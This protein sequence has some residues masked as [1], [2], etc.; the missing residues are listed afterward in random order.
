MEQFTYDSLLEQYKL[1]QEQLQYYKEYDSLTGLYNKSTFYEK[2]TLLLEKTPMPSFYIICIDIER[3]KFINELYGTE[4]GNALLQYLSKQLR[5][6]VFTDTH[7]FG[8]LSA[9]I[10]ATCTPANRSIESIETAILQAFESAPLDIHVIPA[11]GIYPTE[12]HLMDVKKMCDRAIFSLNSIKGNYSKHCAVYDDT[13]WH[14]LLQE[15]EMVSR[16]DAA[17]QNDEFVVYMQ[18]KCNMHTGRI[19]GAEALVRW[20]HPK[21]GLIAPNVFIPV[22]EHNGFI[23]KLDVY[24]WES[25]AKW[26]HERKTANLP[27]VPVSVNVSRID[28]I[29]MDLFETLESIIKRYDIPANMLELEITESAYTSGLEDIAITVEKLMH[30]GYTVLM[31]DFG[32][33]YSSLNM[34]KDINI[35]ILKLDMRF[36]DNTNQKSRDILESIVRMAKWLNLH[37]IAEGVE[38]KNQEDFLLN[39][40]CNYA[41]GYYYYR[42]MPLDEFSCLLA[43]KDAIDYND[44]ARQLDLATTL[45]DFKDLFHADTINEQLM[46]NILGGIAL[47]QYDGEHL[48]IIRC[49][50]QYYHI[51]NY[52]SDT[53]ESNTT[54]VLSLVFE[55]DCIL[56][57]QAL[58]QAKIDGDKGAIVTVRRKTSKNRWIWLQIQL[59]HLSE[60]NG[61]S[62][63]YAALSD[64]TPQREALEKLRMSE[65]RF[66]VAMDAS[67]STLFEVDI[68]TRTAR[69]ALHSQEEFGLD[70]VETD[71]PEGFIRQGS[72]C[73]DYEEDFRELYNAIYRGDD[74]A[75]CTIQ[76]HMGNDSIVWN[77]ITL[78]AI[79]NKEGETLKAVGL[80]ENVTKEKTLEEKLREIQP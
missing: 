63:F 57:L 71:A 40:G 10:F 35:D 18:P 28:I 22:F 46:N 17:L 2:V 58:Q 23:K 41:Q 80:V 55:E 3:F 31:D 54:D 52:D 53:D 34:L 48:E 67:H 43:K 64:V 50:N 65:Q 36:L 68:T 61:K 42:P 5:E 45:I 74:Y 15:Q 72:V 70:D 79:K 20:Q 78:I 38:T 27:C 8:R 16:A 62:I 39:V 4:Q 6:E 76:A 51:A 56:L 21:K 13:L 30:S 32:S 9:D 24:I 77:R 11:I 60:T 49:N 29:G 73:P 25:V 12:Y 33:G 44:T 37:I 26:Q 14:N 47:Y 19:V 75:S 7:L 59:F 66:R 1:L 69:Y